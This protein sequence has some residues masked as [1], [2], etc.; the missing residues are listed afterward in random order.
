MSLVFAQFILLKYTVMIDLNI[1][2]MGVFPA[3]FSGNNQD[4]FVSKAKNCSQ[5]NT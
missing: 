4:K 1:P 5:F 2:A 3:D